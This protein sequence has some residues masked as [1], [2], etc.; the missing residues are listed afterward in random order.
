MTPP[1]APEKVPEI[2]HDE[3]VR[4]GRAKRLSELIAEAITILKTCDRPDR[5]MIRRENQPYLNLVLDAY[6]KFILKEDE[7]STVAE[8]EHFDV[9]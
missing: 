6:G 9:V 2:N 5:V 8:T 7:T 4:V 1:K 3:K